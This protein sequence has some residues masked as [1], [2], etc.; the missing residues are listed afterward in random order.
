MLDFFRGRWGDRAA[1]SARIRVAIEP[2]GQR[3][4]VAVLERGSLVCCAPGAPVE[5]NSIQLPHQAILQLCTD[6]ESGRQMLRYRRGNLDVLL[7][8]RVS[9]AWQKG[10]RRPVRWS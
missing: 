10:R 3:F 2:N 6:S 9:E 4:A 5:G 8:R 1:G 7:V